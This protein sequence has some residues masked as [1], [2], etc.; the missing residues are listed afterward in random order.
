L[1]QK[2][3]NENGLITK[4][5][6][7]VAKQAE[8]S[9]HTALFYTREQKTPPV[10]PYLPL[11]SPF[12]LNLQTPWQ[13]PDETP[14]GKIKTKIQQNREK[15]R[16]TTEKKHSSEVFKNIYIP[17]HIYR[18]CRWVY[19]ISQSVSPSGRRSRGNNATIAL[20]LQMLEK[21]KHGER[22]RGWQMKYFI[23]ICSS[24]FLTLR[25]TKCL[26]W[27]RDP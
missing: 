7:A 27:F 4:R 22:K 3:G 9:T 20:S 11:F 23:F 18:I 21:R 12:P 24:S 25:C 10:G 16:K 1:Q 15:P 13:T 2:E 6:E 26:K 19:I 8:P 14:C 5:P 17:T